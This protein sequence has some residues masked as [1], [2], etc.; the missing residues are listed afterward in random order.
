VTENIRKNDILT[1]DIIDMNN[2]GAGVGKTALG[3]VV[4]VVGAVT[5]DR[6]ECKIIK[7]A[8]KFYV[9]RLQK[10][11]TPS[12]DRATEDFCSA[13]QSCGG[14]VYRNMTRES[15]LVA[16]QSYLKGLFLKAGLGEVEILP[17]MTVSERSGY[18]NK[19]QYPV[20][21][22]KDGVKAGFFANKTHA[23]VSSEQCMLEPAIFSEIVGEIC[24]FANKNGISAYDEE[25]GKGVLRHIYLRRGEISG[26]VM[27]CL[28][29]NTDTMPQSDALVNVIREQ[30]PCVTSIML[31]I[32]KKNTNVVTSDK[33]I[34][35]FGNGYIED[36]LCGLKFRISPD[37]FWQVN[38]TGAEKLYEL[39]GE[40]AQLDGSQNVLDLYCGTGTI[41]LSM[42]HKAK[43][44]T[45][46][47]IVEGAVECAK[48]NAKFNGIQNAQFY[49]ADA[50]DTETIIPQDKEYD[51]VILDPPRKGTTPELISYIAKRKIDRVVYISCGPDTLAR[52][53]AI[54]KKFGYEPSA[55]QPVD[56]FPVTGHVESVV[57][58]TRR[59]D[60]DMRR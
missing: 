49:C 44:V 32:N 25:S 16:K 36:T 56:M 35:L 8:K 39:A 58:L 26:Q 45:G 13:P 57:C 37:S 23:I 40:L 55:V 2:L 38:R 15:E 46:V 33:Y 27:V 7:V 10:I 4:F 41:G 51:V 20:R 47:E 24:D 11:I 18:R 17:V 6:V 1:I 3:A 52:D 22:G 53:V 59:L 43:T 42:A 9:A 48:E 21:A 54:F 14:C 30:F 12:P 31:N 5:G 34:T 29:I 19:A 50:S 60:V 28:V